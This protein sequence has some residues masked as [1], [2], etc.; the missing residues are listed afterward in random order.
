MH[1]YL[2]A[3]DHP[4]NIRERPKAEV[5][6]GEAGLVVYMAETSDLR[7]LVVHED[8]DDQRVESRHL[9]ARVAIGIETSSA[10]EDHL[11]TMVVAPGQRNQITE[12]QLIIIMND[13]DGFYEKIH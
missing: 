2:N 3:V 1:S 13:Q 10:L 4:V 8:L 7:L 6:E 12:N 9:T 11:A 5:G